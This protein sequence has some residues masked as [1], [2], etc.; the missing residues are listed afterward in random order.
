MCKYQ[1]NVLRFSFRNNNFFVKKEIIVLTYIQCTKSTETERRTDVMKADTLFICYC[2]ISK[3]IMK[4]QIERH[5]YF[6]FM[7][8]GFPRC[9]FRC[10]AG[11][12][13]KYAPNF[14][15]P[16]LW[17]PTFHHKQYIAL[18]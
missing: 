10:K 15:C 5:R 14:S 6:R 9:Y 3:F 12:Q 8:F 18:G 11:A 4:I 1:G 17:Q 16:V 13:H 2:S 7:L